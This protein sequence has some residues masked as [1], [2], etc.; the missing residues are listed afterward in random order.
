MINRV[1]GKKTY[2]IAYGSNLHVGQMEY[3][4]PGASVVCKGELKD[5]ELVFQGREGNA[6]ANVIPAEG[7]VVPVVVWSITKED[8]A[9]LDMY[10]GVR[11]GYYRKEYMTVE[12]K[13]GEIEGLI[14]IMNPNPYN[15]PDK[16]YLHV[17]EVGYD[18]FGFDFR[19]LVNAYVVSKERAMAERGDWK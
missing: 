9:H 13:N 5:Y 16:R 11:G 3:R 12:T 6:H 19:V 2:Y 1:S 18:T 14:Y 7:K 4:C 15:L 8:E 10:E 17:I